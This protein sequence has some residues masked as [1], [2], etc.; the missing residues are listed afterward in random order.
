MVDEPTS[1]S[2]ERGGGVGRARG[3]LHRGWFCRLS[4]LAIVSGLYVVGCVTAA[5]LLAGQPIDSSVVVAAGLCAVGLYL[6]DR[7]KLRDRDFDSADLA[8]MPERHEFLRHHAVRLRWGSVALFAVSSLLFALHHPWLSVMP[9]M[10]LLAV[11]FY[12]LGPRHG[13]RP[14][15]QLL[16]KNAIVAAAMACLVGLVL[17]AHGVDLLA[18][19][20][21]ALLGW[22]ALVVFGDAALSDL[23]DT[24]SDQRFQTQT[25]PNTLGHPWTW[26]MALL[27]QIGGSVVLLTLG[28]Q[29]RVAWWLGLGIPVSTAVLWLARL[30]RVRD[31]IDLRL[32]LLVAVTML[33]GR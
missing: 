9:P 1:T 33:A 18:R 16:I 10:G 5:Y 15:D 17:W 23:D 19:T 31:P 25:L 4:D 20:Q 29:D 13:A 32:P 22:L 27:V 24:V 14:K 11:V 26:A 7:V 12:S 3:W 8:A 30:G 6:I 2:D 28:P 21:F